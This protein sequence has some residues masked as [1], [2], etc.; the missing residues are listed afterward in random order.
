MHLRGNRRPKTLFKD[1]INTIL[2]LNK[3]PK[4]SLRKMSVE[5]L[6]R[7]KKVISYSTI[8]RTLKYYGF[9]AFLATKK[10]ALSKKF[11]LARKENS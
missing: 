8:K 3:K 5:F 1:N 4:T 11:I 10:P 2:A 7:S 6:E 9:D